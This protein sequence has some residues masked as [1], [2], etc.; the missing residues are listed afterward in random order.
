MSSICGQQKMV[1]ANRDDVY[2]HY[3]VSV[4]VSG[5]S[6]NYDIGIGTDIYSSSDFVPSIEYSVSKVW[7]EK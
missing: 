5:I 7:L 3:V 2:N 1:L 6:G 4:D